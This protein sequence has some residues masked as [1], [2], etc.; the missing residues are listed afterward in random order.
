M[1]YCNRFEPYHVNVAVN[2]SKNTLQPV[3]SY[4]CVHK[5][6]DDSMHSLYSA[7]S[8][9]SKRRESISKVNASKQKQN[10]IR[11]NDCSSFEKTTQKTTTNSVPLYT[12]AEMCWVCFQDDVLGDPVFFNTWEDIV[13]HFNR[14]HVD[15]FKRSK[16]ERK[17]FMP[18]NP[19]KCLECKFKTFRDWRDLFNHK[20]M[21]CP[22]EN[23][24]RFWKPDPV[25]ICNKC[26]T[27]FG[28]KH[29][30]QSHIKKCDV[31]EKWKRHH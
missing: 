7:H 10:I 14:H 26:R 19:Y 23:A 17:Y 13:F 20:T 31:K 12:V 22:G 27:G 24:Q 8:K 29:S 2:K 15:R 25:F 3:A 9:H 1:S 4:N 11:N 21:N 16:E 6:I 18:K 28:R 5:S 30:L